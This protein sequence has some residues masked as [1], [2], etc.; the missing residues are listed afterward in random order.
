MMVAHSIGPEQGWQDLMTEK[1]TS[2]GSKIQETSK[3]AL[4]AAE[5][6]KEVKDARNNS[7]VEKCELRDL[8]E[9]ANRV[10]RLV[11]CV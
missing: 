8:S 2:D 10:L 7:R 4:A 11:T 3:T 1:L 9:H 6:L 5:T